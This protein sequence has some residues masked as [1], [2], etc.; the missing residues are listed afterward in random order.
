M[1]L[2][3]LKLCKICSDD[4]MRPLRGGECRSRLPAAVSCLKVHGPC[5]TTAFL[6]R[7]GCARSY[8]YVL[9][10]GPHG[11]R[12]R[13]KNWVNE[14]GGVERWGEITDKRGGCLV[15]A[16]KLQQNSEWL[17]LQSAAVLQPQPD[18]QKYHALAMKKND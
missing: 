9:R 10:T 2:L 3:L 11:Q 6:T 7:T 14:G 1:H 4:S 12:G 13:M 18:P 8:R 16:K 17:K 5:R 15:I